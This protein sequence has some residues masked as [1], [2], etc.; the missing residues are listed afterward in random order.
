M[1]ANTNM[2]LPGFHE[3]LHGLPR[4]S[5]YDISEYTVSQILLAKGSQGWGR[6]AQYVHRVM[7]KLVSS[8]HVAFLERDL[9][10]GR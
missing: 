2:R 6:C 8:F 10:I 9:D 5:L 1:L 7:G 4:Y 3:T